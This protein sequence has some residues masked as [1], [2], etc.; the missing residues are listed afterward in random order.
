MNRIRFI[1]I[2][3]LACGIGINLIFTNEVSEITGAVLIGLGIGVAL[4]GRFTRK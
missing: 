3:I 1:G 2:A 4:T